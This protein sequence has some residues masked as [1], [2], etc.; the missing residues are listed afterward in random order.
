MTPHGPEL[1]PRTSLHIGLRAAGMSEG[2]F[3]K[4]KISE[5]ES[6]KRMRCGRLRIDEKLN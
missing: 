1:G 5:S 2:K 4:L 6:Q 3:H